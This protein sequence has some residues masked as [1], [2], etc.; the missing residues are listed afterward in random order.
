MED[1]SMIL[2]VVG[3]VI[4]DWLRRYDFIWSSRLGRFELSTVTSSRQIP[5]NEKLIYF[6]KT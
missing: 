1:R 6:S 3:N 2:I 4:S 5:E